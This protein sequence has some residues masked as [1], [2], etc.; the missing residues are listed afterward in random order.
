M[1]VIHI[2]YNEIKAYLIPTEWRRF[3]NSSSEFIELK[4]SSVGLELN[5][6]STLLFYK[7]RNHREMVFAAVS[8]PSKQISIN[9]G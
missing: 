3:L 2:L 6:T 4:H 9:F 8:T 1:L 7:D 5:K